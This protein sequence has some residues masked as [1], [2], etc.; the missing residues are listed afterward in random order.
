[1]RSPVACGGKKD[2][3][4]DNWETPP[5]VYEMLDSLFHFT[6]DACASA[7]NHK[8]STYWTIDDDALKQ[9]W[10]CHRVFNNPP[11]SRK[12]E[13]LKKAYSESLKGG[14][15]VNLLPAS[16]ETQWFHSWGLL[17]EVWALKGRIPFL[18]DGKLPKGG[19]TKGSLLLIYHPFYTPHSVK[20][21]D[22]EQKAINQIRQRM[23]F[24]PFVFTPDETQHRNEDQQT[25]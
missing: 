15:S 12:D 16:T 19:N 3:R 9:D 7:T 1:M 5:I 6:I 22:L 20:L 17:A 25:A 2:S 21:V 13:F 23:E 24:C 11:F 4:N 14:F 8:H 10:S 18:L